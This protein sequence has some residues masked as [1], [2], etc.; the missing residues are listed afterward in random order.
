VNSEGSKVFSFVRENA[1]DKVFA[2]LNF[3]AEPRIFKLTDG[4]YAGR[5]SE[6]FSGEKFAIAEGAEL[7]L[8][9][10]GYRVFVK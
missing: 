1:K 4:P 10:W 7:K 6:F 9:A 3:S 2:V 5:Y 8:P